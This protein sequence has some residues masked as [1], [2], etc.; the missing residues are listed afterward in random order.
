MS[1]FTPVVD[2][3]TVIID[4]YTDVRRRYLLIFPAQTPV[5]TNYCPSP[6]CYFYR[7]FS[8]WYGVSR[9]KV[10]TQVLQVCIKNKKAK[11][12]GHIIP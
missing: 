12:I 10:P 4:G 9:W 2:T 1:P 3:R 6:D 7:M 5:R 8:V 11:H